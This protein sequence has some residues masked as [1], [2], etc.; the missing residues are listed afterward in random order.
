MKIKTYRGNGMTL[1]EVL[2]VIAIIAVLVSLLLP[3]LSRP[4]SGRRIS[5]VNNLKQVG[6]AFLLYAN[7]HEDQ[8]PWAV[9]TNFNETNAS[10]S[11]EFINSPEV[12]RHYQAASN[13]LVSPKVLVCPTDRNRFKEADFAKFSNANVSYF[14]ALDGDE[15]K[16]QRLLSGDRNISGGVLSNGFLRLLTPTNSATWTT[17]IHNRAGNVGLADGSVQQVTDRA[18]QQQLEASALPLIRLAIP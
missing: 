17:N 6:L 2:V 12:F 1:V 16:P 18:W 4:R 3:A 11:R 8:F 5:C 14:V 10:G 7:D 15:S 13:E 9:S